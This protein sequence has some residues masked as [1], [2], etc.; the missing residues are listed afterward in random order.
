MYYLAQNMVRQLIVL[1]TVTGVLFGSEH[2]QVVGC[3][4]H[5]NNVL[6]GSKHCPNVDCFEHRN[7]CVI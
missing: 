6:F 4:E 3:F 7:R 5:S 1:D 2:G